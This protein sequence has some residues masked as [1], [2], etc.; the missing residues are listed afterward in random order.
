MT[1][2]SPICVPSST[3]KERKQRFTFEP[4]SP[5]IPYTEWAKGQTNTETDSLQSPPSGNRLK[6][7]GVTHRARNDTPSGTPGNSTRMDDLIREV[8]AKNLLPQLFET[9]A[10]QTLIKILKI[11]REESPMQPHHASARNTPSNSAKHFMTRVKQNYE[12]NGFD[13]IVVS[14]KALDYLAQRK[15]RLDGKSYPVN[16]WYSAVINSAANLG[17]PLDKNL[18]YKDTLKN[19]VL[20]YMDQFKFEISRY[21]VEIFEVDHTLHENEN[22]WYTKVEEAL[23]RDRFC[24][25]VLCVLGLCLEYPIKLF[26]ISTGNIQNFTGKAPW[27]TTGKTKLSWLRTTAVA[28]S[29][30]PG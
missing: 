4:K 10:S 1:E 30:L 25:A 9:D 8:E 24:E 21:R 13:F 15:L 28:Y 14:L 2:T 5:D 18:E 11:L 12:E 7:P 22:A 26:D 23:K 27:D 16:S 19:H 20:K 29:P 6:I 17:C 3:P